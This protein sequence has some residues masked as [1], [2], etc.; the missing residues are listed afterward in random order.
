MSSNTTKCCLAKIIKMN[1]EDSKKETLKYDLLK[2]YN[3]QFAQNQNHHQLLFVQVV[4]ILLTVIIGFGYSLYNFN[5]SSSNNNYNISGIFDFTSA[6]LISEGIM[7]LGIALICNM[8]LGYRREQL[9]NSFIREVPELFFNDIEER[10]S[11]TYKV[12][13]ASYNPLLN[14]ESKM[15]SKLIWFYW[16]PNFHSIF[17]FG[18][19]VLQFLLLIVY[20]LKLSTLGYINN[21]GNL[22]LE[23]LILFII[24]FLFPFLSIFILN[25]FHHKIKK[26]YLVNGLQNK[27]NNRY[28]HGTTK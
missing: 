23:I 28:C 18:F 13:P 10:D 22:L 27:I 2:T 1:E 8:A 25:Y 24:S 9:I 5:I 12:Y 26:F 21:G 14:Y 6:L 17:F 4:S 11:F 7:T 20:P 3:E 19:I 15:N 16:M